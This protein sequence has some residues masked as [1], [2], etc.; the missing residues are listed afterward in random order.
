MSLDARNF[1][2]GVNKPNKLSLGY[3]A[4]P[5]FTSNTLGRSE[6]PDS[7]IFI[8]PSLKWIADGRDRNEKARN[9][10]IARTRII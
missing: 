4:E 9:I 6:H 3:A 1:L 10:V 8:A 2:L 5:D 7:I